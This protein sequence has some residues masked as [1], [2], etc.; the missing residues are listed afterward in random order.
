MLRQMSNLRR[1]VDRIDQR[2]LRLLQQRTKL[3]GEIGRTKRRHGAEVYVPE[4][5]RELLARVAKLANGTLTA[6]AVGAIFREILSSSRAA[7]GQA[8]IGVLRRSLA[9]VVPAARCYFGACDRFVPMADWPELMRELQAGRLT[10][11]LLTLADLGAAWR[12]GR[13]VF[14]GEIQ[15]IGEI[16]GLPEVA[17]PSERLFIVKAATA[18]LPAG[19]RALILIECK[20][21]ADAVNSLI[22]AMPRVPK[23]VQL[24]PL[25]GR[26]R[27]GT[28]VA[29]VTFSRPVTEASL[30]AGTGTVGT[31]LGIY[32]LDES[33]GG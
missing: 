13:S 19:K 11:G 12:A 7:Q 16:R 14:P 9:A 1:Q 33:Y 31:L 27:A 15:V 23:L 32:T 25:P 4:R 22:C 20:P 29:A 8:P 18:A 21:E 5:E 3:S 10:I 28:S 17:T 2:L 30:A 24:W 6:P 26:G